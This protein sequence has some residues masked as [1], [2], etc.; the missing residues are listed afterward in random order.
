MVSVGEEERGG[1]GQRATTG[2][3]GRARTGVSERSYSREAVFEGRLR[4][5]SNGKFSEPTRSTDSREKA[6]SGRSSSPSVRLFCEKTKRDLRECGCGA[7]A[8]ISAGRDEA[9]R[10]LHSRRVDVAETT[11]SSFIRL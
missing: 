1:G 11:G 6:S 5:R 9:K 3:I 10:G 8:M 7:S 4:D 2:M